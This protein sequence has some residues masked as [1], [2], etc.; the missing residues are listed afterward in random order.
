MKKELPGSIQFAKGVGPRYAK[1]LEKL[2]IKTIEDLLYYFPRDYQDRSKFKPLKYISPGEEITIKGK[3]MKVTE[4]RPR[5]GLSILK[6]TISDDTD[7]LNCN[8]FNQPYLKKIFKEGKIFI[9]NGKVNEKSWCFNKK[10][11]NN[12]VFEEIDNNETIHTGRVVP[13]YALTNGITQK[14]LRQ[15]VFN[16]IEDY[17][18]HLEEFLPDK[19]REKYGFYNIEKSIKGLHFP[20]S[21]KHYYISRQRFAYQELFLLQLMVLKRK[22]GFIKENGIQH[23][24]NYDIQKRFLSTLPFELTTAQKRVWAEIKDNMEEN[25]PMQKLLQGDVGSGKTIVAA[26]ALL[27]TISSGYQGVLMAPTEILAEQHYLKLT[28]MLENMGIK[29]ELLCGSLSQTERNRIIEDIRQNKTQLIIGTHALFQEDVI[30]S[31]IGLIVIDEQHRFGVEQRYKLK[32]KGSNPDLLVMTATPIPR[33]LALTL[34]GDLDLSIIDELPPGRKSVITTWRGKAARSGVYNFVRKKVESGQQAYIVCPLIE[35]SEEINAVSAMELFKKLTADIF[36]DL[37]TGLLHS[38]IKTEERKEVMQSFRNGKL[39]IMVS[40]TVIEVGVDV[41]NASI[42]LIEN[43]ERFGL[44]QLHQLRGRVGRGQYQSYCI[45]ISNPTTEEAR[46]RME[47]MTETADGF[48]IAEEDLKIRGPG[49]FFGTRQHGIPD[50]KVAN[51]FKDQ[52]LIVQARKD[53]RNIISNDNWEKKFSIL[54]KKVHNLE[55]MV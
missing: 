16:T 15:I 3:V 4:E 36:D 13:I 32:N 46:K 52:K 47:V 2:N 28:D 50:L 44:A 10:E 41:P 40:T 14:R 8:W 43:A 19:L 38:K 27:K 26:L 34:Y 1:L 21:R 33:S 35:P 24:N 51:I 37:D 48:K 20:E 29:I 45:L 53:A 5:K 54:Y 39:D 18:C 42:M 11:V 17:S 12:P 9:F 25:I 31:K 49:E 55:L 6:V 22:K 23:N 30:Y 7:V